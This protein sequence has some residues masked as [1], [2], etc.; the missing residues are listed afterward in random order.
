MPPESVSATGL[1][2]VIDAYVSCLAAYAYPSDAELRLVAVQACGV[3]GV[4]YIEAVAQAMV[5]RSADEARF[6]VATSWYATLLKLRARGDVPRFGGD[7]DGFPT[8]TLG[9]S[10][11]PQEDNE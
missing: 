3:L 6:A 11:R 2:R 10:T 9:V 1:E 5:K 8:D 7:A 4:D